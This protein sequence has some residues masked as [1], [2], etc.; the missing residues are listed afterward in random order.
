[1]MV[2]STDV[3]DG[4]QT[5]S[6]LVEYTHMWGVSYRWQNWDLHTDEWEWEKQGA[7][8]SYVSIEAAV[9]AFKDYAP[10]GSG[11]RFFRLEPEPE[12]EEK[13]QYDDGRT[14]LLRRP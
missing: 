4:E 13:P 10:T 11:P 9:K 6:R 1:M 3:V 7:T 8:D 5:L 14:P 12:P 2:E